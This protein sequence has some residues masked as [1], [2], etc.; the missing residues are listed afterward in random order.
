MET[1]LQ[2]LRYSLRTLAK[3]PAFTVIV[4][5][6]LAIGIGATTAIFSVVNAI[7]LRPLSYPEPDHLTMVWMKNN[8]LSWTR[9]GTRI[10]ITTTIA[11][12]TRRSKTSRRSII[13]G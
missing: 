1:L 6:A 13:R 10:Q 4:V 7:L 8:R 9:T 5:L 12:R 3:K 11:R 2:D